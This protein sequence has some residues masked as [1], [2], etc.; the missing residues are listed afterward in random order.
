MEYVEADRGLLSTGGRRRRMNGT[1][2]LLE[3][4]VEVKL[5]FDELA[6]KL[7]FVELGSEADG[8][9]RTKP[10]SVAS[11]SSSLETVLTLDLD[12]DAFDLFFLENIPSRAM[13]QRCL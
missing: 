12:T 5:A 9:E 10:P 4:P 2:S 8:G 13:G 3:E 7:P 1:L 6:I 11:T